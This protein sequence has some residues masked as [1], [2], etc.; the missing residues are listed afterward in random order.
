M[1]FLIN[2]TL[3]TCLGAVTKLKLADSAG[4][5]DRAERVDEVDKVGLETVNVPSIEDVRSKVPL[6]PQPTRNDLPIIKLMSPYCV[7]FK[8]K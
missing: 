2:D 1:L 6:G 3:S 4:R 5:L 8:N 7:F